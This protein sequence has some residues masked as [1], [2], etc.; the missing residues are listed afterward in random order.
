MDC[1]YNCPEH[2]TRFTWPAK[3]PETPENKDNQGISRKDFVFLFLSSVFLLGFKWLK[4]G[5]KT[6]NVIRP[7]AALKECDF[8]DRCIRCGN[9][10]KVCPTNGLQ[11]TFLQGGLEGI[12]TPHL[13][14]EIGYCEYRCTL[15]GQVCPTGAIDRVSLD[16]K[17]KTK[18]GIAKVDRSICIAW[19]YKQQ[20]LV[21]E[22]HCPISEKAIKIENENILGTVIGKPVVD[23]ELCVG[24]GIC[25]TKCPV[26]P[27]RAI[28][29][30][31]QGADRV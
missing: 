25:Q 16:R 29:V 19:E 6:G 20:C 24:C 22:E 15:C 21:C 1:V 26:R 14:P 27:V 18:L 31:P 17:L 7:P 2:A 4:K 30:D 10:M 3:E 13:V 9:C 12:W 5:P 8:L 28:K 23:R 11:P